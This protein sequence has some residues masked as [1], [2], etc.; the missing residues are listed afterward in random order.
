MVTVPGTSAPRRGDDCTLAIPVQNDDGTFADLSNAQVRFSYG[1]TADGPPLQVK[2]DGDGL[3]VGSVTVDSAE[4]PAILVAMPPDETITLEAFRTYAFQCRVTFPDATE[5]VITGTFPVSPSQDAAA[6]AL[7]VEDGTGLP[8]AMAYA[9]VQTAD[10]YHRVRGN[11]AW[12]AASVSQEAKAAA[13]TRATDYLDGLY[14]ARWAGRPAT[15]AQALCWPRAYAWV[16]G[17]YLPFDALPSAL[18]RACCEAALREL[19]EPGGLAPD[20]YP[21]ERAISEVVGPLQV[22]YAPGGSPTD[23]LPVV[24]AVERL[25]AP[26]LRSA[27]G[28]LVMR[29]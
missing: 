28:A 12:L 13:L 21:G 5:T 27:S 1:Y 16:Q 17:G 19:Q 9:A 6:L 14:R 7:I 24:V 18:V 4:A 8:D 22:D 2:T 26:L 11:D 25:I 23:V 20:I 15:P 3:T 29:A 10:T